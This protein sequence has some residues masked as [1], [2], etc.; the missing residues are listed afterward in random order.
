VSKIVKILKP[1]ITLIAGL[2]LVATSLAQ[3]DTGVSPIVLSESPL[4]P[5][6][7]PQRVQPGRDRFNNNPP[8]TNE[9]LVETLKTNKTFRT[10]LAKHFG[11]AEERVIEFVQDALIPQTLAQDTRVMNYGVTK[12]GLIYSKNTKLK[13]GTRVWATRDGKPILKWD[14][15]NPLLPKIPVLRERPKA[16]QV[17]RAVDAGVLAPQ[18]SLLAP[19][20]LEAPVGITLAMD[21]PGDPLGPPLD[22]PVTIIT[23]PSPPTTRVPV[24]I[25]RTGIP[26]IPLAG[27]VGLVVRSSSTPNTIPEPGTLALLA[28]GSAGLLALRRRK[29]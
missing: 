1:S 22:P 18:G 11:V 14:C 2:T 13:K 12:S 8:L 19:A 21:T 5:A 28:L 9:D 26:L 7:A 3:S 25:A 10:N 6:F 15:S 17:S 4:L 20:G 16:T 23:P 29:R 27:V 24:N